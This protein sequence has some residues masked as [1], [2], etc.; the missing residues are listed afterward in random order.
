VPV[1][2]PKML[3]DRLRKARKKSS[4]IAFPLAKPKLPPL[5]APEVLH[6]IAVI[7]SNLH[8]LVMRLEALSWNLESR[9]LEGCPRIF[10]P[11]DDIPF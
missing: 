7:K 4:K 6:E 2:P 9:G 11:D 8:E 3:N 10:D 1:A 5:K